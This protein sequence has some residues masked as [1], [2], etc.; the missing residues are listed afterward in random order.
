MIACEK[1]FSIEVVSA[2]IMPDWPALDWSF[3]SATASYPCATP[4]SAAATTPAGAGA[5]F[6][7]SC[8]SQSALP[9]FPAIAQAINQASLSYLGGGANCQ[10]QASVSS[11]TGDTLNSQWYID[12]WGYGAP[13]VLVGV[14]GQFTYNFTMPDTGPTPKTINVKLTCVAY[15]DSPGTTSTANVTATI[16]NLSPL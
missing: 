8:T 3:Q 16:V 12:I 9:G 11:I 7:G 5:S 15:S 6:S 14:T 1:Q 4:P 10:I 13:I 2:G